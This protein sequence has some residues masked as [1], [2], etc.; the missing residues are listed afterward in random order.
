MNRAKVGVLVA[1]VAMAGALACRKGPRE[2]RKAAAQALALQRLAQYKRIAIVCAPAQGADPAY[3]DIILNEVKAKAPAYFAELEACECLSGVPVDTSAVPP[4]PS[5]GAAPT[6]YDGV[7]CLVYEYGAGRVV[8]HF[9][10]VD[11]RTGAQAWYH[12]LDTRDADVV[13]RLKR[14]GWWACSTIKNRFYRGR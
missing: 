10:L 4:R 8:L 2:D 14:H 12:K 5:L 6:N 3:A 7:F 11:T 13:A 1:L 9:Y